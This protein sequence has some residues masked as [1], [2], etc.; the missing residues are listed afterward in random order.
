V[1]ELEGMGF[2]AAAINGTAP[3]PGRRS[4]RRQAMIERLCSC[5]TDPRGRAAVRAFAVGLRTR[6]RD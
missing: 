2:E 5:V 4:R 3:P 1:V 6:L